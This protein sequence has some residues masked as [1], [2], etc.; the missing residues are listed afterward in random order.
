MTLDPAEEVTISGNVLG[1]RIREARQRMNM[2]QSELAGTDYSVSYISAI[3]RN[4]IRPSLRALAWLASR[5]NVS[6][7]D[8]LAT[9]APVFGEFSRSAGA[10]VDDVQHTLIE[11]QMA[12]AARDYQTAHQALTEVREAV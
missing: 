8:L 7:S 9:D 4:K 10:D 2:T 12:L 11:A 5:L 3:E 6:L 1:D